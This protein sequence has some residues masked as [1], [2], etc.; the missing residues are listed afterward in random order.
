M[1]PSQTTH[2]PVCIY[3]APRAAGQKVLSHMSSLGPVG[4]RLGGGTRASMSG[5]AGLLAAAAYA[6]NGSV[7]ARSSSH[8]VDARASL[9]RS[10]TNSR[11]APLV[12][13]S[14]PASR[15]SSVSVPHGS[16]PVPPTANPGGQPGPPDLASR[17]SGQPVPESVTSAA[18]GVT[19]TPPA[20][21]H[22]MSLL[23]SVRKSPLSIA[24]SSVHHASSPAKAVGEHPDHLSP[25]AAVAAAAAMG[26]KG[27]QEP[28][29]TAEASLSKGVGGPSPL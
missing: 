22:T 29:I 3:A 20:V 16:T 4:R 19:G 7:A 10:T 24:S 13:A 12:V 28:G 17:T 6:S 15:D 23:G 9:E 26:Q 25:S 5:D 2:S 21:P 27:G 8:R 11:G 1:H 14:L 18:P